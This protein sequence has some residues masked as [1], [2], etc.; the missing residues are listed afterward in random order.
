MVT[1]WRHSIRV[2]RA[3]GSN[4]GIKMMMPMNIMTVASCHAWALLHKG[5]WPKSM[6]RGSRTV[7]SM[8]LGFRAYIKPAIC[9]QEV[10]FD[11]SFKNSQSPN[12]PRTPTTP[13]P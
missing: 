1:A 10:F 3:H 4:V 5:H 12:K 2:K 11:P 8:G 6:S 9:E 13:K 7:Q